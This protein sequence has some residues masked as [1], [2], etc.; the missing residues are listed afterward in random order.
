MMGYLS[1]AYETVPGKSIK[2]G[3]TKGAADEWDEEAFDTGASVM[4]PISR[5]PQP[6]S[7]GILALGAQ[8][9]PLWRRKETLQATK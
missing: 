2:A 1:Y 8:S 5:T 4:S 6:A 9:V 3:Q 7:L